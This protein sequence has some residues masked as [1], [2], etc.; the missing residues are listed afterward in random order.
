MKYLLRLFRRSLLILLMPTALALS[1][2]PAL[3]DAQAHTPQFITVHK[4]PYCGCCKGWVDYLRRN[5]FEVATNDTVDMDSVK[6]QF[7]V[8]GEVA[9]CHTALIDGYVIE[10]HVPVDAIRRLLKERPDVAGI[11]APGMP[12]NSPGMGSDTPRGYNVVTFTRQGDIDLFAR[13]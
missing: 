3:A 11:S 10:G 1:A 5:G 4:S 13:Y 7:H 2:T 6:Q 12:A 8:P 9:S